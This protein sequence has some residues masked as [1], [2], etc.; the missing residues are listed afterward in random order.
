MYNIKREKKQQLRFV[1]PQGCCF[2]LYPALFPMIER[3]K[4]FKEK[5][6]PHNDT[7]PHGNRLPWPY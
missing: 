2:P 7:N 1:P 6:R 4:V 3:E 5:E